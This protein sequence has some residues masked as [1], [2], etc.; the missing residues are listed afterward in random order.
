MR[1]TK[2]LA[3]D[4][5]GRFIFIRILPDLSPRIWTVYL[6]DWQ[7][8]AEEEDHPS[9][10]VVAGA[11]AAEA[12]CRDNYLRQLGMALDD[13]EIGIRLDEVT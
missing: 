8:A 12:C 5:G 10:R 13:G 2:R 1:P 11:G 6:V 4:Q 7:A 3:V 9:R